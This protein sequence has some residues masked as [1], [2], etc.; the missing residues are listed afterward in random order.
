M[1]SFYTVGTHALTPGGMFPM[2]GMRWIEI[3]AM[4]LVFILT[5]SLRPMFYNA[6]GWLLDQDSHA[7]QEA[8]QWTAGYLSS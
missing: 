6:H 1:V 8:R 7:D 5:L 4:M 3:I 2:V